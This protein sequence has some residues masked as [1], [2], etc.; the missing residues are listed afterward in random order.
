[1][2][3]VET[4]K[5]FDFVISEQELIDLGFSI[6]YEDVPLE[7]DWGVTLSVHS[8]DYINKFSND[9]VVNALLNKIK[10]SVLLHLHKQNE[11]S[12][13]RIT[14]NNQDND[15]CGIKVRCTQ[16]ADTAERITVRG[17]FYAVVGGNKYETLQS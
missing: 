14:V 15:T 11:D 2:S 10:T 4:V 16:V 3:E 5:H 6:Q 17:S 13:K 8:R 12:D 9:Y 1:M 7:R